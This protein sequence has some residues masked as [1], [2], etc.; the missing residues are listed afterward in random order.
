MTLG[1]GNENGSSLRFWLVRGFQ[2]GIEIKLV[3]IQ[4]MKK[5]LKEISER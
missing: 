4:N 1:G 5:K 2:F 3:E